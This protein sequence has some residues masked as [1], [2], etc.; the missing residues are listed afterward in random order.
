MVLESDLLNAMA[1][2]PL[3]N[4][5]TEQSDTSNRTTTERE[6]ELKSRHRKWSDGPADRWDEK[7]DGSSDV[8]KGMPGT[9]RGATRTVTAN[10]RT[11]KADEVD[12][13]VQEYAPKFASLDGLDL[14]V[15]R[16]AEAMRTAING[17]VQKSALPGWDAD[18]NENAVSNIINHRE[19]YDS[20]VP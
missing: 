13:L 2:N 11:G 9:D 19:Q 12:A 8:E 4:R 3:D 16:I 1:Q 6:S 7:D 17:G 20:K 18:D 15:E 10:E 14:T 5:D